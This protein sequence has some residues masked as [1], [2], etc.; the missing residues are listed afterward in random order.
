[1]IRNIACSAAFAAVCVAAAPASAEM[2]SPGASEMQGRY[3]FFGVAGAFMT[4]NAP[5]G[6]RSIV[7]N[8][9]G[10]SCRGPH[11]PQLLSVNGLGTFDDFKGGIE[12]KAGLHVTES[13]VVVVRVLWLGEFEG[14]ASLTNTG[15]L[16]L[17]FLNDISTNFDGANSAT[18]T[19]TSNFHTVSFGP[20]YR[21]NRWLVVG[22][23]LRYVRMTDNIFLTMNDG[24]NAN[25]DLRTRNL[26]F[27]GELNGTVKYPIT[28]RIAIAL[29]GAAAFLHNSARV[30]N[31]VFDPD[32]SQA[33]RHAVDQRSGF[34]FLGEIGLT[35]SYSV[36]HWLKIYAGYRALF[37]TGVATGAHNLDFNSSPAGITQTIRA[38]NGANVV[39]HGGVVGL[40]IIW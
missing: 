22:G 6:D 18:V 12:A 24:N 37:I 40:K 7:V 31:D 35:G 11:C 2:M 25:Y 15:N 9:S 17:P 3:L 26:M 23:G 36:E 1:M 38:E 30:R 14:N 21:V 5:G 20:R 33:T 19:Q 4:R 27:G 8:D 39:Y 34:S 32:A 28:D 13:I 10:A 16:G 29:H